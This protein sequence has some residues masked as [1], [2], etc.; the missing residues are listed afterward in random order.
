MA[1]GTVGGVR[2]EN[3][4]L[5]DLAVKAAGKAS[6]LKLEDG[7]VEIGVA[8]LPTG[9]RIE[10]VKKY[11]DEYRLAPERKKGTAHLGDL[12]SFI[13]LV[14]RFKDSESAIFARPGAQ[15]QKNV[16]VTAPLLLAVFNYNEPTNITQFHGDNAPG[17]QVTTHEGK[18]RFGDHRA[19]YVFPLSE[20]WKTWNA[21]DSEPLTQEAFAAF[22]EDHVG[23]V[24]DSGAA[25]NELSAFFFEKLGVTFASPAR[26]IELSRG[27]SVRVGQKVRNAQNLATGEAQVQ[28]IEEHNDE[29]GGPLKVPGAFLLAIPVF[30]FGPLYQVAA[31]L[32][33][34]VSGGNI[35]WFFEL[36]RADRIFDHAFKEACE[37]AQ[38]DTSLPLFIGAPE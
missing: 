10:S 13:A 28:F 29:T 17:D 36:H 14:N 34:R 18:P 22:L 6:M 16:G 35:V 11:M 7:Q 9:I 1:E 8:V 33:Y 30:Q 25:S 38:K 32:R 31:R 26:L 27:L 15:P 20:E 4:V 19:D 24:A 2:T 5:A 12:A 21:Q 3:D 23:D 37:T